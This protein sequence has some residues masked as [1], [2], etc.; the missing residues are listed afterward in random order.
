[1]VRI[2]LPPEFPVAVGV[3]ARGSVGI[4]RDLSRPAVDHPIPRGSQRVYAD[5]SKEA[6]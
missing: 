2:P 3:F 5:G 4:A 6:P 1:M